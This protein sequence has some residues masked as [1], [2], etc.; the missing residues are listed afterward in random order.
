MAHT[1][2]PEIGQALDALLQA[3]SR[4]RQRIH[5]A[6]DE[7]RRLRAASIAEIADLRTRLHEATRT[8]IAERLEATRTRSLQDNALHLEHFART[9]E[10]GLVLHEPVADAVVAA[11]VQSVLRDT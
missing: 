3:E 8:E 2:H 6:Q 7:A 11:S 4:A 1:F 9:L 5:E 10:T